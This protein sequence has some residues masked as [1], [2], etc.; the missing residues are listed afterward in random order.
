M[1]ASAQKWS[2]SRARAAAVGR[3]LALRHGVDRGGEARDRL[4]ERGDLLLGHGA[5]AAGELQPRAQLAPRVAGRVLDGHP[6]LVDE[7]LDV[8]RRGVRLQRVQQG[9]DLRARHRLVGQHQRDRVDAVGDHRRPGGLRRRRRRGIRQGLEHRVDGAQLGVLAGV[10][11][12]AADHGVQPPGGGVEQRVG[13]AAAEG[14][15]GVPA[16]PAL[17]EHVV[18]GHRGDEHGAERDQGELQVAHGFLTRPASSRIPWPPRCRP[19]RYAT[20]PAPASS[21]R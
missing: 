12:K 13:V 10:P 9:L 4:V 7:S 5:G 15:L 6:L 11:G 16:G 1:S 8:H 21:R 18:A 19:P 14:G 3:G 17:L 2:S 20:R